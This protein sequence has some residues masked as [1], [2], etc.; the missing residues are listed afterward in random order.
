MPNDVCRFG[1]RSMSSSSGCSKPPA[2]SR[3]A[4]AHT[5]SA[6]SPFFS[7]QPKNSTSWMTVRASAWLGAKQ[8]RNSS[9]ARSRRSGCVHEPPAL[10]GVLVEPDERLADQ[11]R[12]GD[13]AAGDE[14]VDHRED[15]VLGERP[16]VDRRAS[17]KLMASSFG[18]AGAGRDRRPHLLGE[19]GVVDLHRVLVLGTAPRVG[20]RGP[21]RRGVARPVLHRKA[22]PV[23]GHDR[24]DADDL[25]EVALAALDDLVDEPGA[26]EVDPPGHPVDGRGRG[27]RVDDLPVLAE[28]RRVELD[29]D[30]QVHRGLGDDDRQPLAA[31]GRPCRG[32]DVVVAGR[33]EDGVVPGDDPVA[34]VRLAPRDGALRAQRPV[35]RHRVRG[36]L[37]RVVVEVD[38]G[39]R[40]HRFLP[41]LR[42]APAAGCG[43][44]PCPSSPVRRRRSGRPGCSPS[45]PRSARAWRSSGRC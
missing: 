21:V 14:Q 35:A 36:V 19:V 20:E 4:D 26:V 32:E 44:G 16:V 37:G 33:G 42:P 30:V 11:V 10:V 22:Q 7:E 40:A 23:D 29:R 6:R 43:A 3:L 28:V 12:G 39:A 18:S 25:G 2:S 13:R 24:R 15:L 31:V 5:S 27:D 17:R 38:D 8:R 41:A 34:A 1:H 9:I 45:P